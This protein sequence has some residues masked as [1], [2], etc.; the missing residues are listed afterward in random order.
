M[1]KDEKFKSLDLAL[2]QIEKDFGK[3]AIMRLGEKH[4]REQVD[5]I[6]TGRFL[7]I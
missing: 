5:S 2:S 1:I 3:E 6:P 7:F 4:S